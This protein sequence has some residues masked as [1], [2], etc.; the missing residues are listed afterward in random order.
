MDNLIQTLQIL[1]KKDVDAW[2]NNRSKPNDVVYKKIMLNLGVTNLVDMA[3]EDLIS[4]RFFISRMYIDKMLFDKIFYWLMQEHITT[5][6]YKKH[7]C[8]DLLCRTFTLTYNTSDNTCFIKCKSPV[9]IYAKN[10]VKNSRFLSYSIKQIEE[11]KNT[12]CMLKICYL[13]MRKYP[14]LIKEIK[15]VYKYDDFEKYDIYMLGGEYVMQKHTKNIP[16]FIQKPDY[17]RWLELKNSIPTLVDE[18]IKI[19]SITEFTPEN[20]KTDIQ[21]KY[22]LLNIYTFKYATQDD[23]IKRMVEKVYGQIGFDYLEYELAIKKH[24]LQKVS[25]MTAQALERLDFLSSSIE[26]SDDHDDGSWDRFVREMKDSSHDGSFYLG[27]GM[28]L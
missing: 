13:I 24:N 28:Y 11:F 6:Q 8:I 19:H 1:S 3:Y 20:L 2:F 5:G 27:D 26:D 4:N 15:L 22:P 7:E 23:I 9:T 25:G 18:Y 14:D 10:H 16:D 21:L 17:F 12:P